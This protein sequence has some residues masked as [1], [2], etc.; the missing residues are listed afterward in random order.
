MNNLVIIGNGFDLAHNM[1]TSYNHFIEYLI[2]SHIKSNNFNDIFD[3]NKYRCTDIDNFRVSV[4][5]QKILRE[6][7]KNKFIEYLIYDYTLKNWSDIE[8]VYYK[9]LITS[10]KQAYHY[11]KPYKLNEEFET[12]KNYLAGYLKM[13]EK[14]GK[15]IEIYKDFFKYFE[16]YETKIL[17]FNSNEINV[18]NVIH[19]HG[20][21]STP[22]NPIVFGYAAMD[23]EARRLID[24]QENEYMRN[25]KKQLYKHTENEHLLSNYLNGS[26]KINV[27]ILG[28]SCGISDKLILNQ[29]LNHKNINSICTYYFND[30]EQY[31][32]TQVNIDR[33]M[34]DD[35]KFRKL[36]ID[37]NTCI[38]MP[39][40]DDTR[41]QNEDFIKKY[42]VLRRKQIGRLGK[43]G[44]SVALGPRVGG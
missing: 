4:K 21:L 34:N 8:S 29:I 2:D 17:N 38:R 27:S 44:S 30:Y 13:Q 41:K 6:N 23:D 5:D 16:S 31:F 15:P 19:I 24:K 10:N 37:Y 35:E 36:V 40:Y 28:H 43:I 18:N 42:N 39:Q 32:Q 7:F 12:L 25:I 22:I 1:K 11:N 33:I 20:E 9:Q 26:Q 3:F 14:E